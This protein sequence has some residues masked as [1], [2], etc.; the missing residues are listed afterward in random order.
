MLEKCGFSGRMP[1]LVS[2]GGRN[3]AFDDFLTAHANANADDY[4][5]L[6]V[7][8]EDP[9][10]DI[11]Q[12]WNHLKERDGWDKPDDRTRESPIRRHADEARL[13]QLPQ[14]AAR[15]KLAV[16][17]LAAKRHRPR[18]RHENLIPDLVGHWALN[19]GTDIPRNI[20]F[21]LS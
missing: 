5:A 2:C 10:I 8:S 12:P 17:H 9:V 14:P 3:A 21:P 4:V 11:E 20:G 19:I 18:R 7:D 1:R 15:H 16:R 6:L 13:L